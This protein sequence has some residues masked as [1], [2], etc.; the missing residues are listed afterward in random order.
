MPRLIFTI[1][2]AIVGTGECPD[3]FPHRTGRVK[4]ASLAYYCPYCAKVWAHRTIEGRKFHDITLRLCEQHGSG[5]LQE[6]CFDRVLEYFPRD[7]LLREL[8]LLAK[9]PNLTHSLYLRL[10]YNWSML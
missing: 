6:G 4:P 2:Q 10:V 7:V 1:G 5:L 9:H 3:S 8:S